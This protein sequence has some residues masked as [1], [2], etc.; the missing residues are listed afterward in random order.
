[1]SILVDCRALGVCVCFGLRV[2]HH[3]LLYLSPI[4]NPQRSRSVSVCVS[5]RGLTKLNWTEDCLQTRCPSS[6]SS[7]C[8]QA[9]CDHYRPPADFIPS[10]LQHWSVSL[11]SLLMLLL[12]SDVHFALIVSHNGIPLFINV[13]LFFFLS[14]FILSFSILEQTFQN[15]VFELHSNWLPSFFSFFLCPQER[16][17]TSTA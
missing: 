4:T 10:H 11:F 5:E 9:D 7:H 15:I 3:L 8:V 1:M 16:T 2:H 17:A 14:F 12:L 6:V 13:S